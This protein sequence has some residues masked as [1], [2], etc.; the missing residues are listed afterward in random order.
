MKTGAS[1]ARFAAFLFFTALLGVV[2][3]PQPAAAF[4]IIGFS[5][6]VTSVNSVTRQVDIKITETT[7][8]AGTQHIRAIA[9]WGDAVTDSHAWTS[10]TGAGPKIYKVSAS[11]TYPDITTRVITLTSDSN[12]PSPLQDTLQ[13]DFGC[14]DSPIF[15]CD[16]SAT[17]AALQI[18]NN[19]DDNKDKLKFKWLNGT[20][21]SFDDPTGS[22]QYFLCIYAPGLVFD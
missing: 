7:T 1:S 9:A 10:T 13:V 22:T 15:F 20:V 16:G 4:H 8:G 17:K 21:A 6:S 5:G 11:H 14:A 12:A 2:Q 18:Q 19:A 3:W